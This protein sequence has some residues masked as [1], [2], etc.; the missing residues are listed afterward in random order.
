MLI[1]TSFGILWQI[2][3]S[4]RVPITLNSTEVL[5]ECESRNNVNNYLQ[6]FIALIDG[7]LSD[8]L[9]GFVKLDSGC[10]VEHNGDV[11]RHLIEVGLA[12]AQ[13]RDRDVALN[14]HQLVE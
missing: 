6:L 14:G 11:G 2:S 13:T 9:Q 3:T 1:T 7:S 12:D 5:Y 8:S 4:L 10:R